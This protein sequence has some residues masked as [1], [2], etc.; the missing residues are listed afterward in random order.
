MTTYDK[1]HDKGN[2]DLIGTI[3]E[4]CA[5]KLDGMA[6]IAWPGGRSCCSLRDVVLLN[7]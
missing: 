1:V 3:V 4:L 5:G 2:P 6:I 7:D